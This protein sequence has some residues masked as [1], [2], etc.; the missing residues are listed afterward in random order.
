MQSKSKMTNLTIQ[1]PDDLARGL[2]GIAAAQKKSVEQVALERL[3]SFLETESSPQAVLRAVRNLPHPSSSALDDLDAAL[4]A[5]R[6]PVSG[7]SAFDR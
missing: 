6:L 4:A 3:G 5:A 7:Q 2:E 1:L